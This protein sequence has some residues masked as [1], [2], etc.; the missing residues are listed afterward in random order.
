[1]NKLERNYLILRRF[2]IGALKCTPE[3]VDKYCDIMWSVEAVRD[4]IRNDYINTNL[5]ESINE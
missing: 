4:K 3:E 5:R 1:M 2:W